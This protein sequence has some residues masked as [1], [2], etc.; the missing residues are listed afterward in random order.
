MN[1]LDLDNND[2][3]LVVSHGMTIKLW[4]ALLLNTNNPERIAEPE[5]A[6]CTHFSFYHGIPI[7]KA[8][9]K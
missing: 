5:N 4:L 7:L 9:S 1:S 6:G 3:V 2:Q 8:Y